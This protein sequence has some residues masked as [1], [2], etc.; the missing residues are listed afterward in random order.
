MDNKQPDP[1]QAM[2]MTPIKRIAEQRRIL[3]DALVTIDIHTPESQL[4]RQYIVGQ[5][6]ALDWAERLFDI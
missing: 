4:V 3:D 2:T 1:N 5:I 6:R